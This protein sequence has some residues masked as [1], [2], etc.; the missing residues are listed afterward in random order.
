[1]TMNSLQLE[2]HCG[3]CTIFTLFSIFMFLF[4]QALLYKKYSH[5]SDVWSYG[6]VLFEIWTVGKKPFPM[7][8]N[9][10]MIRWYQTRACQAPPPGCPR[11]VYKLMVECWYVTMAAQQRLDLIIVMSYSTFKLGERG[12]IACQSAYTSVKLACS[13]L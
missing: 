11:A 12:V 9:S 3:L 10:Q 7:L 1:M 6:M 2:H 5:S 8:S 4:I 13:T